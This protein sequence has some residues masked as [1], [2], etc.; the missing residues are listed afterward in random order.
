MHLIFL[1]LKSKRGEL[2]IQWVVV[3]VLA[4]LFLVILALVYSDQ[5]TKLL[6]GFSDIISDVI[7]F[8]DN[9]DF[10]DAA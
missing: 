7:G 4:I 5:L 3:A 10:Q 8:S 2:A 9:V 1:F 6:G